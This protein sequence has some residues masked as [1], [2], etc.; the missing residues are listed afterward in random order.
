MSEIIDIV[1][2]EVGATI[3]DVRVDP[4]TP[5]VFEVANAVG[6][7]GPTG[8]VG[9]QGAASTVPGPVG[10]Q[11]VQGPQGAA[12]TVPG[13]PGA[14]GPAGS[15]GPTGPAST[16]PGPQGPQGPAGAAGSPD[17]AAQVLAKLVTVDGTGSGLDADLFDGQDSSFYA[18]IASPTF[19]GDPQAPTA[20]VNDNDT[21]IAT[22]AF[23]KT[24]IAAAGAGQTYYF[25]PTDASDVATYKRLLLTP[26]LHVESTAAV[27]C[28]GTSDVLV[29]SFITDV[30]VPGAVDFPAGSAYRRL[31]GSVSAGVARFHLQVYVRTAAGAE[32]IAR[33]EF[34]NSFSNLTA[35]L[36]EWLM[37]SVGALMTA[38]DR[39]VTKIYAQRVSGPATITV[40][41]YAEG[42]L[43]ASQIQT[44]ISPSASAPVSVTPPL[45]MSG[46]NISIDLSGYAPIA[47][48]A[49][50]GMP[51]APTATVGTNTTQLATT[52]FVLANGSVVPPATV[53]PI[54]DGIAAVGVATKYAREDHVHPSDVAAR[55][56]RYDTAQSLTAA[57]KAQAR[58]NIDV[59]KKNYIIN[60]A[61]M[62]SQENGATAGTAVLFYPVD[63][64]LTDF[65]G[66]T[67]VVSVAQVASLSPAGSPN[68]LRCTVTTADAAVAI[69]DN[70]A[71]LQKI[72][73]FRLVDLCLGLSNAKSFTIQFGVK[74][75]A[76]TYSVVATN[77]AGSRAYVAEYVIS[78]GETNT[79]VLKSVTFPPETSGAWPTNNSA[80]MYIR[81]G[82]MAGSSSAIAPGNWNTSGT[83]VY[84]STNQFNVLGTVGNTFELFDVGMY[85]GTVAP[86]F[87]VPDYAAELA[88][89]QRYY[90]I[91][92]G[93]AFASRAAIGY[94]DATTSCQVVFYLP[95]VLR[96]TPTFASN[97]MTVNNIAS[98]A[99][100]VNNA[101]ANAVAVTFT[102]TGYTAN[103]AAQIYTSSGGNGI[104]VL[105]ARL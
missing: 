88:S 96:T 83:N 36:Q 50:T 9:P 56:V 75:P 46:G 47:S 63:Q 16:V 93:G 80:S 35:A 86:A 78:A 3:I 61:M 85:E 105:N 11:G 19:T 79:D 41:F 39:I 33:D 89:C 5:E 15:T 40:T 24:A 32:T 31:Y 74:A 65:N 49:L 42:S 77:F 68:R 12:S 17:T 71:I 37:T 72:E 1:A 48:P 90:W 6:P 91:W 95:A 70:Y 23:V 4:L 34:S 103:T 30:G 21:S 62:I 25:D 7:V 92:R 38:T 98:A 44:T 27:S 58:A 69:S 28:N 18:P 53:A 101:S 64:F 14:T 82:L 102:G 55:A 97:Q 94:C 76:G 99:G 10:P 51:T 20:S 52:A 22:T 66:T 104:V 73:G 87:Q 57:Q 8:P 29:G 84:G 67:G 81:W 45:A 2:I 100:S 59:L 13:P 60:G 26:S 54:I 43:H